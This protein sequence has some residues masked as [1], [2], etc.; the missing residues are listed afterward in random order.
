MTKAKRTSKANERVGQTFLSR[1]GFLFFIKEYYGTK[2]VVV[3]FMDKH[4][5]EVHTTYQHCKNGFVKNPYFTS[6]YGVGCL[7]EI[8][9]KTKVDGVPTREYGLW[10]EMLNRCY[11]G[12][13]PSY[14]NVTVCERWLCYANF[15][16]DLPKIENYDWW[17]ENPN[18]RI[19]MDKDLK[20]QGI[21]NKVYSLETVKFISQSENAKEVHNRKGSTDEVEPF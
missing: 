2:D 11:S 5:A 15:L 9:V 6:V 18:Q 14:A 1:E 12:K 17:L 3:K 13:Y 21:E 20:Q 16:E 10:R 4:G 8:N 19:A 7:G